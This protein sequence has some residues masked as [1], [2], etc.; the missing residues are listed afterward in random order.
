MKFRFTV[1]LPTNGG[2]PV[3]QVI[4]EHP[5]KSITELA[6]VLQSVDFLVIEELYV[7]HTHDQP[8]RYE[9]KG[10]MALNPMFIGKIKLADDPL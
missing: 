1:N 5:A 3:H 6:K 8:S 7:Y 10:E 2:K 4:G 9:N